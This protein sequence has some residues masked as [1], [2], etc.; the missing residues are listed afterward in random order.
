MN[1]NISDYKIEDFPLFQQASDESKAKLS[2]KMHFSLYEE[3]AALYE[4]GDVATA[5]Y[6]IFEGAV[7]QQN[8]SASG[9]QVHLSYRRSGEYVGTSPAN[10]PVKHV[11]RAVCSEKSVMG[12]LAL[13]DFMDIF[14]TD[15]YLGED[16][17]RK[18]VIFK[19]E[20]ILI[21]TG[22][23]IL[24]SYDLVVIDL[25][26]RADKLETG[27]V[28]LPYRT[29]WAAYL[30]ITPE[31]LSRVITA[32]KKKTSIETKGDDI[33]I[34]DLNGLKNQLSNDLDM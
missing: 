13:D 2:E 9:K 29:E 22:K 16:L 26:R 33:V 25:L 8:I 12:V 28:L 34:H 23:Q 14:L 17:V 31:T 1:K 4:Y 5:V 7:K 27:Y 21:R 15:R 3:D 30:G 6:F 11:C 18:L 10:D 19:N 20:Q 24:T 32:L